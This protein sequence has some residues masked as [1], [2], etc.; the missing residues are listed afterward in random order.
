MLSIKSVTDSNA[1]GQANAVRRPLNT[2][3]IAPCFMNS[4]A[5]PAGNVNYTIMVIYLVCK[6]IGYI[7]DSH[8]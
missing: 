8:K 6:E 1:A 4:N 3:I 7:Q 2:V 5:I